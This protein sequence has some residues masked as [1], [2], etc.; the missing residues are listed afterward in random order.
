MQA[1]SKGRPHASSRRRRL[2]RSVGLLATV[3]TLMALAPAA[4]AHSGPSSLRRCSGSVI[5]GGS[6]WR[7]VRG[8]VYA[9]RNTATRYWVRIRPAWPFGW[10]GTAIPNWAWHPAVWVPAGTTHW[11][12]SPAIFTHPTNGTYGVTVSVRPNPGMFNNYGVEVY[13]PYAC[14]YW[15]G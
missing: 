15:P 2:L 8:V 9:P 4:D 13:S 5:F 6:S 10:S 3:A 14:S 1:R 12:P 11:F 7:T